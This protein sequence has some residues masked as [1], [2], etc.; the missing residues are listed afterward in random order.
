MPAMQRHP[1]PALWATLLIPAAALAADVTTEG[2]ISVGAGGALLNGDR[3]SFQ[4]TYQ[5]RKDGFG[6]IEELRLTS[7]SKG[8]LCRCDGRPLPGDDDY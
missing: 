2:T 8:W 1:F 5:H 6:G 4:Q 3:P 7:E